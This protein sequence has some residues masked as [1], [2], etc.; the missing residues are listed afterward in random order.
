MMQV[1]LLIKSRVAV[2]P[3]PGVRGGIHRWGWR[4]LGAGSDMTHNR[5]G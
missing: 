3:T 4:G 5:R 2:I 1:Q